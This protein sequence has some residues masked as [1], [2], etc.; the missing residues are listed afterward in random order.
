ME[1]TNAKGQGAGK[2]LRPNNAFS[3]PTTD[4]FKMWCVFLRPFVKLTDREIDIVSCLLKHRHELSK[5]VTDPA[6]L[7]AMIMGDDIRQKIQKECNITPQHLCVVM[8]KL[9][10]NKVIVDNILNPKLIPNIREDDKG[11]FQLLILFR[12]IAK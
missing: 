6:I 10:K 3:V 12:E 9:R 8:S 5:C 11:V 2:M 7:D 4:F 1:S